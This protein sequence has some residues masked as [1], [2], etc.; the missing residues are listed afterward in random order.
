M[1]RAV[2]ISMLGPAKLTMS[3][4]CFSICRVGRSSPRNGVDTDHGNIHPS[5]HAHVMPCNENGF[6]V[7]GQV[8]PFVSVGRP[9]P[10]RHNPS[11]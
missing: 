1:A 4:F 9:S 7:S 2:Q 5:D 6:T 10:R 8:S 11:G 3:L